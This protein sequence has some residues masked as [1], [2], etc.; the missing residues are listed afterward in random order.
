MVSACTL[1][2]SAACVVCL[3]R[4]GMRGTKLVKN[5][6]FDASHRSGGIGNVHGKK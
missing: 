5:A 6:I 1:G 3:T 2:T 4:E